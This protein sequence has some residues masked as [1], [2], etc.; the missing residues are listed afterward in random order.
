MNVTTLRSK[1]IVLP[2]LAAVAALAVA[3]VVWSSA[4]NADLSGSERDR[5]GAAA[6]QAVGGTAVEVESGD[7]R[8]EAY[9]VTVRRDDGTEVE[10]TLD[11]SLQVVSQHAEHHE[12]AEHAEGNE[13]DEADD[14]DD[15]AGRD[16]R[17]DDAGDR[18][19]SAS[20]RT[21]AEQAALDAVGG[22]TVTEVEAEDDA[23]VAYE[24]EVTDSA[25][26]KWDVE[27][28]AGFTVVHKTVDD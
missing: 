26:T 27:L 23:G 8:G 22:G 20:A 12:H 11:K 16:D 3:G 17:G 4:A 6:T 9:E 1:R 5:V 24:V 25:G 13:S 21:S 7:D 18:A 10:V 2:A 19:L 28:D 14:A 15:V